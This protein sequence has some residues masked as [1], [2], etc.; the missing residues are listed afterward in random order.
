MP[1]F[2]RRCDCQIE[3][4]VSG[5]DMCQLCN[6]SIIL[7]MMRLL[8]TQYHSLSME[9]YASNSVFFFRCNVSKSFSTWVKLIF[10]LI[11]RQKQQ[12][13]TNDMLQI[14][15]RHIPLNTF[16]WTFNDNRTLSNDQ[17]KMEWNE[18]CPSYALAKPWRTRS[19]TKAESVSYSRIVAHI[20]KL[21]G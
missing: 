14:T 2:H 15:R 18:T 10:P 7:K 16:V 12:P 8:S 11:L 9:F 17:S 21:D 19:L 1:A 5:V 13:K 20:P 6:F 3:S 4:Y